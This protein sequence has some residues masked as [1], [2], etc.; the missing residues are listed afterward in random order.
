VKLSAFSLLGIARDPGRATTVGS[1]LLELFGPLR[2][3]GG[4]NFPIERLAGGFAQ[5]YE[6][7]LATLAELSDEQR[8]DVL[9]GTARRFYRLPATGP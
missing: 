6:L 9:A 2:C 4:S 5:W 1:E 3:M 8:A 7:V